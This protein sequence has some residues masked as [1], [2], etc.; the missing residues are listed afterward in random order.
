MSKTARRHPWELARLQ[1]V[2]SLIRKHCQ[3]LVDSQCLCLDLGCGD[4]FLV[5]WLAEKMP[6]GSFVAVDTAFDRETLEH[7]RQALGGGR[8]ELYDSLAEAEKSAQRAADLVLLLDVLEHIEDDVSFLVGLQASS[9]IADGTLFLITVPAFR[10][11]FS[12]HDVFLEH[13]RRYNRSSLRCCVERAGLEVIESGYFFHILWGLRIFQVLLEKITRP[14]RT[15]TQ[16]GSWEG[17]PSVTTLLEYLLL[18]DFRVS[19][20]LKRLRLNLPG[21]SV[22][23]LCKKPA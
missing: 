23:M 17:K 12:S 8:I 19:V 9:F 20:L 15:G 6:R 14:R 10:M 16:V 1:V 22:Y 4:T 2:F 7:L 18:L 11:L 5:D 13:K 21:L 3:V